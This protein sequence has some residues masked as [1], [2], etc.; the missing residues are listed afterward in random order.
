VGLH[1]VVT[2]PERNGI[3]RAQ[4]ERLFKWIRIGCHVQVTAGS[5]E[6]VFGPGA[7]EDAWKWIRDG[8]VHFV[9]SDAHNTTRRP[10]KLK[11]AFEQIEAEVGEE[12]AQALLIDNPLAA[13]E[14]KAL[15]YVPEIQEPEERRKKKRFL[16][17]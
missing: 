6:G 16:F 10:L 4:P 15:P 3:L 14:G 8:A 2:H 1:P 7:R 5:L 17:F 9:A 12:V 13:F 11:F